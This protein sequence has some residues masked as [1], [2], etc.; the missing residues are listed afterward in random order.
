MIYP[1]DRL[2]RGSIVP[3]HS[4]RLHVA[5][6]G[7]PAPVGLPIMGLGLAAL[8]PVCRGLNQ[9]TRS[10]VGRG[11]PSWRAGKGAVAARRRARET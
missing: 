5:A 11:M 8:L 2:P 6:I 7:V 1:F 3:N 4:G 9:S 10:L